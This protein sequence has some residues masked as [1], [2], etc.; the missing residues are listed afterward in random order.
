MGTQITKS[1]TKYPTNRPE[2]RKEG[3]KRTN[4]RTNEG[5]EGRKTNI[6]QDGIDVEDED[7]DN[8]NKIVQSSQCDEKV[9]SMDVIC[10]CHWHI[11]RTLF[12]TS[13]VAVAVAGTV[14]TPC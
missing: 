6:E 5:K 12:S 14:P 3:R 2:G 8:N 13:P 7:D 4:E 1:P 9:A 11:C 10:S